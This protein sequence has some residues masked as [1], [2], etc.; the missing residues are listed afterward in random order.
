MHSHT[1]TFHLIADIKNITHSKMAQKKTAKHSILLQKI[2]A[3][4]RYVS[5]DVR[6]ACYK[7]E[8]ISFV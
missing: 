5:L 2:G 7:S 8:N 1:L 3:I 6:N 4:H